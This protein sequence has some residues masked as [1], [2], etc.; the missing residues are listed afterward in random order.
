MQH[1]IHLWHL[2]HARF[3]ESSRPNS[4][5]YQAHVEST[6]LVPGALP[7]AFAAWYQWAN[8]MRELEIS[9]IGTSLWTKL[10]HLATIWSAASRTVARKCSFTWILKRPRLSLRALA[11]ECKF[12]ALAHECMHAHLEISKQCHRPTVSND[13][14]SLA[15]RRNTPIPAVNLPLHWAIGHVTIKIS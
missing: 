11:Y 9:Q 7:S 5:H 12:P 6:G 10:L 2:Q 4:M 8:R 14:V 3:W 13:Q 15:I 1:L